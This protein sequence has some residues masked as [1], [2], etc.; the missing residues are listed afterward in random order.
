[1]CLVTSKGAA[2]SDGGSVG[3]VA[4]AVSSYFNST[5]SV[6][7]FSCSYNSRSF[8]LSSHS[9]SRS[10]SSSASALQH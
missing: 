9:H 5:C 10:S 4:A 3:V 8:R 1:M 6:S 2:I 7:S